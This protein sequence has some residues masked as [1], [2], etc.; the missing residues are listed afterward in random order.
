MNKEGLE[1]AH[2]K[3][4]SYKERLPHSG[5]KRYRIK[6]KHIREQIHSAIGEAAYRG[7][8][9][10]NGRQNQDDNPRKLSPPLGVNSTTAASTLTRMS[11]NKKG[12]M[13]TAGSR[14]G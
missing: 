14:H 2:S 8:S 1:A 10:D 6:A 9:K 13:L 3:T 5:M 11:Q 7:N 4:R 12:G